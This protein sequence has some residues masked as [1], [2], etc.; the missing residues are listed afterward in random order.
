M[1]SAARA[2]RRF[3]IGRHPA[4]S[5]PGDRVHVAQDLRLRRHSASAKRP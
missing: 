2:D 5:Q 3:G 4:R 1:F